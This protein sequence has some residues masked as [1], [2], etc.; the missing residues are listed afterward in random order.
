MK[1]RYVI[2]NKIMSLLATDS[3]KKKKGLMLGL[4]LPY[5]HKTVKRMHKP[6]EVLV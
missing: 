6:A 4:M 1:K 5:F 3:L 2:Q